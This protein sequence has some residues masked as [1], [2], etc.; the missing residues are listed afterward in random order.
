MNLNKVYHV[1]STYNRFNRYLKC[2]DVLG[3]H[4]SAKS[5]KALKIIMKY[6]DT[7]RFPMT[8]KDLRKELGDDAQYTSKIMNRL[9]DQGLVEKERKA[10]DERTVYILMNN[11]QYQK[12]NV[13]V[14]ESQSIFDKI[15]K[16]DL[17]G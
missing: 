6:R 14:K 1:V 10:S 13:V 7:D 15:W 8:I 12:A 9:R 5:L 17:N 11:A 3:C 4:M 2:H 16:E